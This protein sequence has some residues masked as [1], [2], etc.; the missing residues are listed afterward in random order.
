MM[1]HG[2]VKR[3]APTPLVI[4][5]TDAQRLREILDLP[6]DDFP[7]DS[8]MAEL[9][10]IL[11]RHMQERDAL[12]DRNLSDSPMKDFNAMMIQCGFDPLKFHADNIDFNQFHRMIQSLVFV[13]NPHLMAPVDDTAMQYNKVDAM[14]QLHIFRSLVRDFWVETENIASRVR[15]NFDSL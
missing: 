2:S 14:R 9:T 8:P 13:E 4:S 3:P 15:K 12:Q 6:G 10:T 11:R 1:S 5:A 7:A